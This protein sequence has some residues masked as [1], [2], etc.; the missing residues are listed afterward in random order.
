[1]TCRALF[2]RPCVAAGLEA[3]GS[4]AG[5]ALR[6]RLAERTERE[7]RAAAAEAGA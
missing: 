5:S 2:L 3:R 1:M 7:E 6:R 4:E